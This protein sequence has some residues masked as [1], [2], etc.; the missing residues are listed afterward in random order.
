MIAGAFGRIGDH[1]TVPPPPAET[2]APAEDKRVAQGGEERA[3]SG[4]A[5]GPGVCWGVR[6]GLALCLDK[7]PR[8]SLP[9]H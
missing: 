8:F 9:Y 7:T 5:E 3:I 2:R 6:L 4:C 1:R